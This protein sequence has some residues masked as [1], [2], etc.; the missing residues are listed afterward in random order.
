MIETQLPRGWN[1][2][3]TLYYRRWYMA[4]PEAKLWREAPAMIV[5]M[6]AERGFDYHA[7]LHFNVPP[8]EPL[9]SGILAG[10]A[11]RICDELEREEITHLQ[12]FRTVRDE[13]YQLSRRRRRTMGEEALRFA[14]F[15]DRQL[16]Y[17][18]ELPKL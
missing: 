5:P 1:K 14:G 17:M 7:K 15:F 10:Y 18:S 6:R 13:L 8:E 9:P 4:N 12:A 3:H 2:H 11:L 16:E